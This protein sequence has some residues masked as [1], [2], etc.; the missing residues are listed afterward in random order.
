MSYE[1]WF[2][3]NGNWFGYH[4][5]KRKMDAQRYEERYKK[6]FP[7]LTVELREREHAS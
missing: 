5:F 1:V 6:V 4:S 3:Q 7:K 2:G